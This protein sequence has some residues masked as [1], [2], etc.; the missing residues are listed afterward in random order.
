MKQ[1]NTQKYFK[2]RLSILCV[3]SLFFSGFAWSQSAGDIVFT[4]YSADG[5]PDQ[6]AFM[7]TTSIA[8]GTEI[9]FTDR[10][11]TSGGALRTG[12]SEGEILYTVAAGGLSA[13]DQVALNVRNPPSVAS[14]GGS[15]SNVSGDVSLNSLGDQILAFAG[16]A[17]TPT[18]FYCAMQM[19]G[20]S[21]DADATSDGTSAL[22]TGLTSGTTGFFFSSE[23]DNVIYDC[24]VTSGSSAAIQAAVFNE[25]NWSTDN[26]NPFSLPCT[27]V[28]NTW[29]GSWS[30][31]SAPGAGDNVVIASSTSVG[32]AL[33]CANLTIN[34]GIT[35]NNGANDIT[36]SGDL[37]NNG[38]GISS[39][40]TI[41]FNKSGTA[42]ISGNNISHENVVSVASGT[43]L[44]TGGLLTL[45]ASSA[46]S[47]GQLDGDGSVTGDVNVQAFID[48]STARYFLLGSSVTDANLDDFN[49]GN[50]MVSASGATGT[51][52]Q[53]NAGTADWEAPGAVSST[54]AING[55]G[56][57]IYA[58]T[59]ANGTFIRGAA[60]TI[61]LTGA[62]PTADVNKGL[63]YNN[64]QASGV[65]FVGGTGEASTEGW[66]LV[67]NPFPAIYDWDVQAIP[68]DMSSAIYRSNGTN[69]SSY[70]QG[71]GGGS[72][73]IAP[74]QGFFVQ[75]TENTPGTLTFDLDNRASAQSATLTKTTSY[76]ID[77]VDLHIYNQGSTVHDEL[78]V[79][80]DSQ[81]TAAFDLS[82]D[83]RK[84]LNSDGVPN[85][86]IQF[87]GEDDAYSVY[88]LSESDNLTSFPVLI[89]HTVDGDDLHFSLDK[90]Q[91]QLYSTVEIEDLK[92]G[93][94]HDLG[95][96]DYHF[97]HDASFQTD[98]FR[99]HFIG[100]QSV[101]L[102]E[103]SI[104]NKWFVY[105]SDNG[106]VV[107]TGHLGKTQ[108]EVYSLTGA[109]L[110]VVDS[111]TDI[112]Q[113]NLDTRGVYLIKLAQGNNNS[114]KKLIY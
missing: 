78:F 26:S 1:M 106:A 61:E 69:Y 97:T 91:L 110:Q 67:A 88:R 28:V 70:V 60:G 83:A 76:T 105:R 112:N 102:E 50:I 39:T 113:I 31:G 53:W 35:L 95:L 56:Y 5:S 94:V 14:G 6:I 40:G 100:K 8:A 51:V 66:N 10:G 27:P 80:F 98:R 82:L 47:F 75:L 30:D 16:S 33:T 38:N 45:T 79:G 52:W 54:V 77:G 57:A 101:G 86:Y 43:T 71:A 72:R 12:G 85:V 4:G 96:S 65:S 107:N 25:A 29:S 81:A 49:E 15:V 48:P 19:D 18:T 37:T 7:A 42:S 44:S 23:V 20:T 55:Q 36:I 92:T 59:N 111:E 87:A 9:R 74:L 90:S 89:E 99:L 104:D 13:G 103:I 46:S 22:P 64:G 58:G 21:W 3:L 24:S 11:W 2:P 34:S 93:N 108:I 62:V 68:A 63:A 17:N 84:L 114:T 73:Y 32:S 109:L 41:T